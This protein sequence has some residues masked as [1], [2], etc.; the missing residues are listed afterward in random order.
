MLARGKLY[1]ELD[2]SFKPSSQTAQRKF[3]SIVPRIVVGI[4]G[5][6]EVGLNLTGNIQ[7]GK[8]T[9]TIVPTIKWKALENNKKSFALIA[10]SNFSLPVR[11]ATYGFGTFSYLAGSRDF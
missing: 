2:A 4:G 3:S 9:T 5:R 7:P 11:K 10:G 1:A 8:D 6:I